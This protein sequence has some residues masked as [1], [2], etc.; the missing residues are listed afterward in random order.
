VVREFMTPREALATLSPETT[1]REAS[2]LLAARHVAG[3][4]V[5]A[6]SEVVGVVSAS[7]LMEFAA[8]T[9]GVTAEGAEMDTWVDAQDDDD[10]EASGA[11]ASFLADAWLDGGEDVAERVAGGG[12]AGSN[13]FE[14][15]V[16]AEVMSTRLV[17]ISPCAGLRHAAEVMRRAGVHRLLVLD[18]GRLVGLV[19]ATDVLRAVAGGEL[20]PARR[21][22]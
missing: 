3:A 19:T 11:R 22:E 5:L 15:H 14:E 13:V 12:V 16:V 7:D 4:P 2:E 21:S 18:D 6:G 9:P 10:E 1:L 17:S 8:T 20:L